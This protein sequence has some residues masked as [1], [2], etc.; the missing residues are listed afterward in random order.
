MKKNYSYSLL[1]IGILLVDSKSIGTPTESKR[2]YV[3]ARSPPKP[4]RA[5]RA[6]A[7]CVKIVNLHPCIVAETLYS[8]IAW[9][10]RA[11]EE[12]ACG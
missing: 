3:A 6:L 11:R 1:I 9:T 4:P 10:T 7:Q 8:R 5:G 12:E 2:D